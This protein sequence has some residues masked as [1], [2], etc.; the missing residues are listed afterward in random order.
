MFPTRK[1]QLPD[2]TIR[3]TTGYSALSYTKI[4]FKNKDGKTLAIDL[5]AQKNA[6]TKIAVFN[7]FFIDFPDKT[8]RLANV[9]T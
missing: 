5:N 3:Q 6:E 4:P 7:K 8:I 2:G 1:V 9:N